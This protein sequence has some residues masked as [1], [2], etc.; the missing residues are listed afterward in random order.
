MLGMILIVVAVLVVIGVGL[1]IFNRRVQMDGDIKM[2]VNAIVV[3]GAF[4]WAVLR[5]WPLI[6]RG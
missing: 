4:I 1:T 5:L 2:I 6:P 3:L